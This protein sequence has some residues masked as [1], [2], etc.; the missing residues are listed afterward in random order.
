M[1][2]TLKHL[3]RFRTGKTPNVD[4]YLHRFKMQ[5]KKKLEAA[6]K[7]EIINNPRDVLTNK[8]AMARVNQYPNL[9]S[10]NPEP[11]L[12]L[13]YIDSGLI[14]RIS[15]P[16]GVYLHT[17][18]SQPVRMEKRIWGRTAER[19]LAGDI[20]WE[21][22]VGGK[23]TRLQRS[24]EKYLLTPLDLAVPPEKM[25][26]NQKF[27]LT[28][29]HMAYVSSPAVF[30]ISDILDIPLGI[31]H[32]LAF[33]FGIKQLAHKFGGTKYYNA[34]ARQKVFIIANND[35]LDNVIESFREWGYFGLDESN[36]YFMA[37]SSFL[38][39]GMDE[40]GGVFASQM[41]SPFIHNH[42]VAKIQSTM[43]HNALSMIAGRIRRPITAEDFRHFLSNTACMQ[44]LN[45]EDLTYLTDPI[46]IVSAALALNTENIIPDSDYNMIME[47]VAQ[48][49]KG[50]DPQKGG[51]LALDPR[52]YGEN[53]GRLVMIES[54]Q[55]YPEYDDI[56]LARAEDKWKNIRYLNRNQNLYPNPAVW[57]DEVAQKGLPIA[58]RNR[59]GYFY[60]EV[61]QGDLNYFL[62]T[63]Y[64]IRK[65]KV[66]SEIMVDPI[67]NIKTKAD[68]PK[69]H[70]TFRLQD[71]QDGF[72]DFLHD[73]GY[74]GLR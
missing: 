55:L 31:R 61:P 44:S 59:D 70:A 51:M 20:V 25:L 68:I 49:P 45:V 48:R 26:E 47:V 17:D 10:L 66:G 57:W 37:S 62:K 8:E 72:L 35:I 5:V 19:I 3:N 23:A 50:E 21:H 73:F 46:D 36:V 34:L 6:V 58:L 71:Q 38:G 67:R 1:K 29:S 63:L 7:A 54:F 2:A 30:D 39:I 22:M 15:A 28:P 43:D 60:N 24:R 56:D 32:M 64:V 52:F 11:E 12:G 65:R 27:F 42:G 16:D 40:K 33:T 53:G 74:R 69:A 9:D 41:A 14:S 18:N 13:D 4:T